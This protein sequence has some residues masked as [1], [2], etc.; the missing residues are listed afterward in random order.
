MWG[1]R[2]RER[3]GEAIAGGEGLI[4]S[5]SCWVWWQRCWL[6]Q[7]CPQEVKCR[8]GISIAETRALYP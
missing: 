5:P 6:W 2:E 4:Y 1:I 7:M 8:G 3:R